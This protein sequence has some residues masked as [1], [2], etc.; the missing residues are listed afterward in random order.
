MACVTKWVF[1]KIEE[2]DNV[3]PGCPICRASL[4]PPEEASQ[5]AKNEAEKRELELNMWVRKLS[6]WTPGGGRRYTY[7]DTWIQQAEKLWDDLCNEILD[8]LDQFDFP[9]GPA[10]AIEGTGAIES[11]YCGNAPVAEKF[12]SFGTVFHFYLAYF[13]GGR[14]PDG[15]I[16]RNFPERYKALMKHLKAGSD[17]GIDEDSWRVRQAYQRPHYQLEVFRRR[18][19]QSRARLSERIDQIKPNSVTSQS[20]S[21][22]RMRLWP[23]GT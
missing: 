14:R 16:P 19:E 15:K 3:S 5:V 10:N 13:R 22:G 23:R 12:L 17:A 6:S 8:D 1:Q 20:P 21:G 4:L 2:E 18:M 11:F 9:P 7:Q